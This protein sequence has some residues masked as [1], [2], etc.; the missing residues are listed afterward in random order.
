M[1]SASTLIWS[2]KFFP[3]LFHHTSLS[4]A[5]L[6]PDPATPF[7]FPRGSFG[8][9]RRNGIWALR[10][11]CSSNSCSSWC[12]DADGV[13]L[14]LQSATQ[15]AS[16]SH[17]AHLLWHRTPV[18]LCL[19]NRQVAISKQ[20][21]AAYGDVRRQAGSIW[22]DD[23]TATSPRD[24]AG[25]C[26]RAVRCSTAYFLLDNLYHSLISSSLSVALSTLR[27]LVSRLL[28]STTF[29]V[30]LKRQKWD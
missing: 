24:F 19:L 30:R 10:C 2:E 14:R 18:I 16:V 28:K 6:H 29:N 5:P 13:L 11:A 27:S 25:D 1:V 7:T 20:A 22:H 8:E 15:P 3:D 26:R 17:G 23:D 21:L 9:S 4:T 12:S